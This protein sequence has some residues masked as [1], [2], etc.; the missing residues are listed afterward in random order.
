MRPHLQMF[1]VAIA[2][3]LLSL[4]VASGWGPFVPTP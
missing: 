1:A 3:V 2:A 4:I